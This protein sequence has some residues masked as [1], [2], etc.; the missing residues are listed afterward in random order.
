[1]VLSYPHHEFVMWQWRTKHLR[2]GMVRRWV[3]LY[4]LRGHGML[5]ISLGRFIVMLRWGV[6]ARL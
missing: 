6:M 1:M 2:V 5:D 4:T 3:R